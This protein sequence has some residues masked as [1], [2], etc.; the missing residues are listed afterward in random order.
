MWYFV[1]KALADEYSSLTI[2]LNQ[3]FASETS[4]VLQLFSL[5]K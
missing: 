2:W 5:L 1:M 3:E 4:Y